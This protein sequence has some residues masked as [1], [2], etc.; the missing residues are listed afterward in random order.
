MKYKIFVIFLLLL[1]LNAV[2]AQTFQP[3][4]VDISTEKVRIQG[5]VFYIHH[6][7]KGHTLYSISKAY[8]VAQDEIHKY[9]PQ[10]KEK[11]LQEGMLLQIPLVERKNQP[12]TTQATTPVA[13]PATVSTTT[14][15]AVPATVTTAPPVSTPPASAPVTATATATLTTAATTTPNPVINTTTERDAA[16]HYKPL[17]AAP[18]E[19]LEKEP[20]SCRYVE[21]L[22]DINTC[23]AYVYNPE[24]TRFNVALLLPLS[25]QYI[26][27]HAASD[28]TDDAGHLRNS[29]DFVEFYGGVL[30]A[31]QDMKEKGLAIDISVID[32]AETNTWSSLISGP[33]LKNMDLIVGPVY[34][35]SFADLLPYALQYNIP[36]V[37]PLDP[38]V[39]YLLSDYPNL[40]Q[41]SPPIV[42]QH[43]KLLSDILPEKD[44]VLLIYDG[45]A[46]GE[47][48]VLV[49]TYKSML[50]G[51]RSLSL[52]AYKVSKGIAIRDSIKKRLASDKENRIVVASNSEALVA[53]LTSNLSPL[54]SRSKYSITLYGQARWRNFDNVDL[55]FLHAMNLHLVTPFFVDYKDADV[56]NFIARYRQDFNTD[57]SQFAFHGY[58]VM[59]Y[60]L[61]ALHRYGP[62]FGDCISLLQAK[63]L[64]GNYQ[65]RKLTPHGGFIN[66]GSSLIQYTPEFDIKRQ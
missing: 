27:R 23:E 33:R 45:D 60:F 11:G 7:L 66:T 57:P 54:Q 65:F 14:Q 48:Q 46:E 31:V 29:D 21:N 1:P 2:V 18:K 25:T 47:E 20:S 62:H 53:D 4:P 13:A 56:K 5:K 17:D 36:V 52:L 8:D 37:S 26:I 28:I 51:C 64:Q 10:V 30:M 39:E 38:K 42:C 9:N 50:S 61:T 40:F 55:S 49:N 58:D 34:A 41:V 3:T 59:K 19:S 63:L 35:S 16:S 43:L 32:V 44:N 24:K 22:P 6:V 12:A 15:T